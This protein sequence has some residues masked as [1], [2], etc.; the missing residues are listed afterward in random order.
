MASKREL[1]WAQIWAKRM[2]DMTSRLMGLEEQHGS[3][4]AMVNSHLWADCS[5][6]QKR[7]ARA[8]TVAVHDRLT[9]HMPE[10]ARLLDGMEAD[11][12]D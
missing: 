5:P 12:D 8:R 4:A 1:N 9:K 11:G 2:D 10:I 3:F 7:R 6:E